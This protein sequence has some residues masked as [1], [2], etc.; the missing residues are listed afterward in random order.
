M[1]AETNLDIRKSYFTQAAIASTGNGAIDRDSHVV[2]GVV[3]P[4]SVTFSVPFP[5]GSTY[6]VAP[7]PTTAVAIGITTKTVTGFSVLGA[8][9][10]TLR[11][12]RT[13]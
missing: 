10:V 3:S 13:P 8:G 7:E 4:A 11:A 12:S 2:T 1:R 5:A 9:T 6:S